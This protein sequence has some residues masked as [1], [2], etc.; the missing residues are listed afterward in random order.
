[1]LM[2]C[3]SMSALCGGTGSTI[4]TSPNIVMVQIFNSSFPNSPLSFAS[5]L[6][7]AVPQLIICVLVLWIWLQIYY[8]PIPWKVSSIKISI[9]WNTKRKKFI[10]NALDIYFLFSLMIIDN[11]R[12][13]KRYC[14]GT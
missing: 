5:W 13:R 10:Y 4:G 14:G 12:R 9:Q 7:F 8:L 2:M 11:C 6:A 1:M 3:I